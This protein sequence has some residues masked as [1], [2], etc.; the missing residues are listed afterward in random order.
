MHEKITVIVERSL[1]AAV[2]TFC[3]K[4][5]SN[6]TAVFVSICLYVIQAI[7][8]FEGIIALVAPLAFR[9][10]ITNTVFCVELMDT[11]IDG[12]SLY[13]IELRYDR[14]PMF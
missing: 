10:G 8:T 1:Y 14:F 4:A 3:F 11:E 6:I 13:F 9:Q 5:D 2:T 7:F 12:F